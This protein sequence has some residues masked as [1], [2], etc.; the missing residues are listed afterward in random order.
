MLSPHFKRGHYNIF[1]TYILKT[2]SNQTFVLP[3]VSRSALIASGSVGLVPTLVSEAV[4]GADEMV[5]EGE[6]AAALIAPRRLPNPCLDSPQRM[7]LHRELL[8]NQ[9]M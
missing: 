5:Q 7:D 8:F 3:V 1:H 4:L 6:G 2:L 9:K